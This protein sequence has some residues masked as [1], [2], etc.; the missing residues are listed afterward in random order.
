MVLKDL[1]FTICYFAR[2]VSSRDLNFNTFYFG[3]YGGL[4][5]KHF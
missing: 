5:K 2:V 1:I 4:E 3:R